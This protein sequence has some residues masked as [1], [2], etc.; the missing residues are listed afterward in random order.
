[1]YG[2]ICGDFLLKIRIHTM[3]MY[4][5]MVLANLNKALRHAEESCAQVKAADEYGYAQIKAADEV[6]NTM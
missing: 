3:N 4:V 2:H 5:C 6:T 1:M